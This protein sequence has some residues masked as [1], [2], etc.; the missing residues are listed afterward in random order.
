[1]DLTTLIIGVVT[2]AL[3]AMPFVLAS[4]SS[5]R[6]TKRLVGKVDQMAAEKSCTIGQYEILGEAIIGMDTERKYLFF[7]KTGESGIRSSIALAEISRCVIDNQ[8]SNGSFSTSTIGLKFTTLAG[9][10]EYFEFFNS[11]TDGSYDGLEQLLLKWKNI[12]E[13]N[14]KNYAK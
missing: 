9:N 4:L 3:C 6:R 10:H 7:A 11:A 8:Q 1:M 14:S 2:L 12:I 13:Q 5:K